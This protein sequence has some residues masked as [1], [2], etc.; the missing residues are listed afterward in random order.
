MLREDKLKQVGKRGGV[1]RE[2][3][4]GVRPLCVDSSKHRTPVWLASDNHIPTEGECYY[5]L[6]PSQLR[7][8]KPV[9]PLGP[10]LMLLSLRGMLFPHSFPW[11]APSCDS[12]LGLKVTLLE[13]QPSL[14][15]QQKLATHS[16]SIPSVWSDS[17]E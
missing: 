12:A 7:L 5:L 2:I 9:L 16:P 13:K 4:L 3:K 6:T 15:S 8:L 10:S 17:L 1:G 11:L 14:V